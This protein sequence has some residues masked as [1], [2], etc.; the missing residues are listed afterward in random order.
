MKVFFRG[1]TVTKVWNFTKPYVIGMIGAMA[2]D[3]GKPVRKV[4]R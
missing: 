1:S 3:Y 4:A 2:S